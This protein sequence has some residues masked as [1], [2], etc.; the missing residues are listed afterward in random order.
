M[1]VKEST[2]LGA[3]LKLLIV[4]LF[5]F[6]ISFCVP[7]G[8]YSSTNEILK[9]VSLHSTNAIRQRML[10]IFLSISDRKMV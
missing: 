9:F 1:T 4:Y 8:P 7:I 6:E 3:D 10:N 5:G 2:P